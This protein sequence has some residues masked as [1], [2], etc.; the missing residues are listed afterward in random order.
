[1]ASLMDRYRLGSSGIMPKPLFNS[2]IRE[3]WGEKHYGADVFEEDL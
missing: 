3:S 1:M 2:A